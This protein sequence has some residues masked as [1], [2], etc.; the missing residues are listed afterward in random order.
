MESENEGKV[1]LMQEL[2]VIDKSNNLN[3][4]GDHNEIMGS[5]I[6]TSYE[7]S[8]FTAPNLERKTSPWTSPIEDRRRVTQW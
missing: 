2:F 5:T 6:L 8:C 3:M 4:F 7:N 1:A